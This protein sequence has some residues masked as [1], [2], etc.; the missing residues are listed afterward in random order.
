MKTKILKRI[1]TFVL[2]LVMVCTTSA[3]S[4]IGTLADDPN[5]EKP[6]INI[7]PGATTVTPAKVPDN[8]NVVKRFVAYQI[9][10]GQL[11]TADKNDE[12]VNI[13]WGNAL[14][15]TTDTKID[16]RL[17]IDF[18]QKLSEVE[19]AQ[20]DVKGKFEAIYNEV[21]EKISYES[22]ETDAVKKEAAKGAALQVSQVLDDKTNGFKND[23]GDAIATEM[24]KFAKVVND[25]VT[26]KDKSVKPTYIADSEVGIGEHYHK[27]ESTWETT[28]WVIKDIPVGYYFIND[29]LSLDDYDDD[30]TAP[31]MLDVFRTVNKAIKSTAPT[32]NKTITGVK[33]LINNDDYSDKTTTN[34]SSDKHS[35]RANIGDTVSYELEG[36]LPANFATFYETYSYTFTDTLGAGLDMVTSSG[37]FD[38]SKDIKVALTMDG[39]DHWLNI[40]NEEDKVI[41]T[42]TFEGKVL[43]VKFDDLVGKY[44][45]STETNGYDQ[46]R[47]VATNYVDSEEATFAGG[48]YAFSAFAESWIEKAKIRITYDAKLNK[49]A[50]VGSADGNDNTAFLTYT[51]DP[52]EEGTGTSKTTKQQTKVF[53]YQINLH[54]KGSDAVSDEFLSGAKFRVSRTVQEGIAR[55]EYF[56]VFDSTAAPTYTVT[57]WVKEDDL[58]GKDT[59]ITTP[60]STDLKIAGLDAGTYTFTETEAPTNYDLVDPFTV[61]IT[62]S[63]IDGTL[64]N[65]DAKFPADNLVPDGKIESSNLQNDR[66]DGS[67]QV[68]HVTVTDIRA[69]ILPH[70]GGSGVYFYYIAGGVL[71]AAALVLL[72]VSRRRSRRNA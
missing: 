6:V 28:K 36:G 25:I 10:S 24:Q 20:S 11:E 52:N 56:A 71:V 7:I 19:W 17:V 63:N 45:K 62:D 34:V 42:A 72:I 67:I 5:P 15:K 22:E 43:T 35:A 23:D 49:N 58:E 48:D 29:V 59:E 39:G 3:V 68:A 57:E 37:T 60:A 54:K 1:V 13:D 18:L 26:G 38:A 50:K 44:F 12:L 21:R 8:E 4:S 65:M 61:T 64:D 41:Y 14:V 40:T 2:A 46:A 31:F 53:T 51:N 66:E 27:Y 47:I 70:T 32:L 69:S 33:D 16:Y 55:V 9:F 30:A